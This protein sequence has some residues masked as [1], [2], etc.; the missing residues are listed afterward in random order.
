MADK[1]HKGSFRGVP[2]LTTK[3]DGQIGRR[4]VV[5]EYA[6]KDEA[7]VEDLGLKARV[8]TL[9]IFVLGDNYVAERDA[10]EAAFEKEGSGELVHP[11]RGR[12]TV[13]VTD[14][15]PS[16]SIDQ[17]GRQSWSVTFTQ[18]GENKQPNIRPDTAAIV[19][20]MADNAI[21][22]S[23]N[24]FAETF[25]VD[26]LPEFVADDAMTQINTALSSTLALA[27]GMLPDMAILPAFASNANGIVSKL[28][29]LMRLPTNL[30]SS[31][32]GQISGFLG[33]SSGAMSAFNSLKNLFGYR[34]KSVNRTTP[35]RIQQ[36]N[37]RIAVADLTR[38]TAIIEAARATASINYEST[39][40][41]V[42]VRNEIVDAIETEQLTAPDDVF[43]TLS[44]L[45]TAVVRDINA[46]ATDLPNIIKY[47]PK[48]TLPA[49]VLAYMI[50]GD[51]RKDEDIVNRNVIA[52]PG[53]VQGGKV[54][55]VL[56]D[57]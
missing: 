23:E 21:A 24:D 13:S 33:L 2:F 9:D 26:G 30:A 3:S 6:S 25:N 5:N 17:G 15:R 42:Q 54:L 12:M 50:Y 41:A 52:H 46:R 10:L 47:T 37:N 44:D 55:E 45:R 40:Q 18:T 8:F 56:T 4:N 49:V 34:H 57:D 1:M 39:T 20:V 48:A 16:E 22:A 27:R 43:N 36:D 51:A 31:I 28:T 14:C 38:R 19:D 29:Q 53:F 32:T 11:W 35:S 7:Y